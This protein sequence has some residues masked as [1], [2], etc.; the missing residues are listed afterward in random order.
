MNAIKR[1]HSVALLTKAR[2]NYEKWGGQDPKTLA[3]CIAEEAGEVAQAVLK[4][5]HEGGAD[6]RIAEEAVDLGALCLQLMA[7]IEKKER[8]DEHRRTHNT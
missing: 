5:Y 6:T 1:A 2:K 3:L 8:N 4:Y 7:E